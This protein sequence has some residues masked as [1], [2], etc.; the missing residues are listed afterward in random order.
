M[1]ALFPHGFV[2]FGRKDALIGRPK[3][4]RGHSTL[5]IDRGKRI[6]Q[7]LRAISVTAANIRPD[8]F[9]CLPIDDQPHPLRVVLLVDT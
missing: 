8:H 5:P 1:P 2:A 7:P 6:S 3:I 9:P 4:G